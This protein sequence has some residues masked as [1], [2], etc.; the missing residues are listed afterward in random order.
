V[1]FKRQKKTDKSKSYK[2]YNYYYYY[3]YYYYILH[4]SAKRY[5]ELLALRLGKPFIDKNLRRSS[6]LYSCALLCLFMVVGTTMCFT[7][8]K[9]ACSLD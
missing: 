3:Y 6:L 5:K 1:T 7:Y 9:E 8:Y 2:I 4:L